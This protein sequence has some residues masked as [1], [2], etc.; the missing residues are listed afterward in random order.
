MTPPF[1]L[2]SRGSVAALLTAAFL[3][4]APAGELP[5]TDPFTSDHPV[6]ER[7]AVRGPWKIADGVAECTQ[8]DALYR[9]FKDHGPI[10]FYDLATADATVR[11]AVKPQGCRSV[12]FTLN[13]EAGHVLRFVTGERGTSVRAFPA[14]KEADAPKS[15]ETHREADWTLRDGEWTTVVVKLEQDRATITFGDHAPVTVEHPTY[16]LA[17]SNLSLGFAFG[18]LAVKSLSVSAP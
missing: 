12:V 18:T 1:S 9:K 8:D 3:S 11:Y 7:R 16:S 2:L 4:A 6:P 17:R 13:G 15:I 5:F 14:G 10:I